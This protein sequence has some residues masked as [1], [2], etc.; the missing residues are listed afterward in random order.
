MSKLY[1][2]CYLKFLVHLDGHVC[3]SI[4]QPPGEDPNGYELASERWTPVH[5]VGFLVQGTKMMLTLCL[6]IE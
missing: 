4:L 3:I 5:M 2:L 6:F 1:Q